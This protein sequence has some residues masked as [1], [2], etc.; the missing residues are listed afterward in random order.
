MLPKPRFKK[1]VLAHDDAPAPSWARLYDL[2]QIEQILITCAS[3]QQ[4]ISY[5]RLLNAL[6]YEFSRPKMRSLCV[7]LTALDDRRAKLKQP[8]LA[9]LVVRESDRIPGQG[10]WVGRDT[11]SY[12][13]PWDGDE[14]KAYIRKIQQKLF[15][16][17]K[18]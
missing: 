17:V 3:E 6:G 12:K 11:G 5:A 13:G 15:A 8:E 4:D 10:W 1:S 9:V 7:A 14:A 2:D 16:T 18:K